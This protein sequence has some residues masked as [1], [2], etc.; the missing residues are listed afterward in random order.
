MWL[1]DANIDIRI[2]MLLTE[3]GIENRTAESLGWKTLSNGNLVAAAASAGF[4]CLL[5]RDRLFSE[6]AARVLKEYPSF[7]IVVLQLRQERW[8]EFGES[9]RRAWD[10]ERITPQPGK[11]MLWPSDD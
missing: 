1:L 10:R 11:T 5:T 2:G 3:F 7:A 6:S 4:A 8:P 9:F